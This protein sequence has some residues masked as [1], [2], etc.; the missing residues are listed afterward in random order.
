MTDSVIKPFLCEKQKR[1]KLLLLGGV[2]LQSVVYSLP[3][4]LVEPSDGNKEDIYKILIDHLNKHFSPKQNSTFERHLFRGLTPLDTES[5][6]DFMLRLR[7]QMQQCAFGSLKAEIENICLKDKIIDVWAPLD[8]K[9]RLLGKEYSL[10]EVI[11]ACQVE[12]QINKESKE[13]T[14]RP[15]AEPIQEATSSK[16]KK[17]EEHCFKVSSEDEEEFIRCRVGGREI[18]LIIDSVCKFNL[19]SHADWSLLVKRK[20][21]VFNATISVEP[22]TEE[23]ASFYVI[24]NGEQSLL[25]RDT[26]IKLKVLRLGRNINRIEEMEP[27]PKWKNIE[28]SLSIDYDVKP[29][30]QPVRRIPAA[31]EDKV[32]ER[33]DE[34]LSRD[35]IEP[36]TG[37]SAWI[38][39]IVLAFKEN[40]DIRLYLKD[41]YHQLALDESSREIT[42]F[43]TPRGLFRYKRLMFGVNSAPEIFQ[44]LL[45]QMLSAVPNAMNFIDDVIIFGATDLEIDSAVKERPKEQRRNAELPR[46]VT[47]VGK[48]IP[49][50]A[51]HTDPLRKLLK[52]ESKFTWA[53]REKCFSNLKNLLSKYQIIIFQSKASNTVDNE[54]LIITFASK[55]LSEVEKRYSQFYYYLAGLHFEL[56]TD[57]KP[58]EAIFKPT[59]KPPARIER[60]LL[61]LQ[62]YTFTVTYKSGRDNISDALS[63][64]CQLPAV[65]PIDH[66]TEYSILRVAQSS[67]PRSM[68]IHEIA[69]SSKRDE[70]I[71]DAISCLENDS[72][73]PHS[74]VGFYPFRYELSAVGSLLLRGNRLVVPTSLRVKILE[75]AHEG[76]PGETA[77]KRRL[78]SK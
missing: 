8:L 63:R 70:E 39:P 75:L 10:E 68:T 41:A 3:G 46:L 35:I 9:K 5:F 55:A 31:L 48:F 42:T 36:V 71:M 47:Y 25:G 56:V 72:W 28:V 6:G 2:Q 52:T 67:I 34:A 57:H 11:E 22:G 40:G 66:K 14:S 77:M 29:V 32:M 17:G 24:E 65:E 78:R 27:F 43:I 62:A 54:P 26:A 64:L 19:I 44:R 58:L 74:S 73:K 7:Q 30:Q 51:S 4:A 20:A 76:H 12:E 1:S 33:L 61:R 69:E 37:P 15:I 38:S 59:S 45:E 53:K 49:D 21:T 50:L 13:M 23:I 18:S 60:W 16:L